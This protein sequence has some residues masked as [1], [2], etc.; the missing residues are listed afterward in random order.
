MTVET[1]LAALSELVALPDQPTDEGRQRSDRIENLLDRF[2]ARQLTAH[3]RRDLDEL[4]DADYQA[5]N[6]RADE[7]IRAK[8][9]RPRNGKANAK[10]RK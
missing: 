10:P 2:R 8:E 6:A 4:I 1:L 7:L 5:A 3:D 9:R